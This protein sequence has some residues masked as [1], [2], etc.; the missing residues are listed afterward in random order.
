[1]ED[2]ILLQKTSCS[3]ECWWNAGGLMRTRDAT[4]NMASPQVEVGT[5]ILKVKVE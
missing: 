1:M 4:C 5:L 2:I 3:G